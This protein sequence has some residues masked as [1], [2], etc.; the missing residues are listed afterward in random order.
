ML[1][2]KAENVLLANEGGIKVG[3]LS[4]TPVYSLQRLNSR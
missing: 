3:T 4:L 2:I 1:D